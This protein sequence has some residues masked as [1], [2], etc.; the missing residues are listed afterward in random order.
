MKR[1][2]DSLL[3]WKGIKSSIRI[4]SKCRKFDGECV[5]RRIKNRVYRQNRM[6]SKNMCVIPCEQLEWHTRRRES[7]E[8]KG[9]MM[10]R[11]L[12]YKTNKEMMIRRREKATAGRGIRIQ[13]NKLTGNRRQYQGHKKRVKGN[14]ILEMKGEDEEDRKTR[15]THESTAYCSGFSWLES[16]SE[17]ETESEWKNDKTRRR[18][19]NKR[20]KCKRDKRHEELYWFRSRESKQS[21]RN[22]HDTYTHDCQCHSKIQRP[23]LSLSSNQISSKEEEEGS[24]LFRRRRI[25]HYCL[26]SPSYT[27]I[28]SCHCS[29][30]WQE[31]RLE[32]LCCKHI[33]GR[34][35]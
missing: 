13:M 22:W 9:M 16:E 6:S 14:T 1:E 20:T 12:S 30:D 17:E 35:R 33:R 3:E 4:E 19:H 34:R 28:L 21:G 31:M 8:S 26:W 11:D 18:W 29:Q 7:L 15:E 24:S 27:H 2:G 25:L 32:M 10:S 23:S 5:A